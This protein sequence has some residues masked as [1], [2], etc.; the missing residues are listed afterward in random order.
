V[1][2]LTEHHIMEVYWWRGYIAP[3]I[4]D[5]G[6]RWVWVVRFTP[7]P[8]YS[9]GK[10]PCYPLDRRL[11]GP[12]SR[13]EWRYINLVFGRQWIT[14]WIT[15]VIIYVWKQSWPILR[16]H[17]GMSEIRIV[18]LQKSNETCYNSHLLL[19]FSLKM[20]NMIKIEIT[21]KRIG[22]WPLYIHC[23]TMLYQQ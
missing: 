2:S 5:L 19:L 21:H 23:L 7:Q 11:G 22:I 4:L 17:L 12:Q 6:T 1:L 18:C 14:T 20:R 15:M 16:Y 9:Q 3:H 13:S 8:L 10:S